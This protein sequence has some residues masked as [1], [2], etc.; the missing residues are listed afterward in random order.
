MSELPVVTY[1]K[2]EYI[3]TA[4][5]NKV[6]RKSVLC[7]AH[8]IILSGKTIIQ[9]GAIVRGDLA[10]VRVG[11]RCVISKHV[12]IRPPYKKISKG[13]TFFP[14]QIGDHVF[15][16]EGSVISA[17]SIGSYV[18]IG[19]NCVIGRKAV[20]RDCCMI[21]DNSVVSPETTVPSYAIY[22]GV[23]ARYAGEL[24]G[25]CQDI[26]ADYTNSYYLNFIPQDPMTVEKK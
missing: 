24:P 19:K 25:P 13:L 3:E 26:M 18:H 23:P 14:Q 12:V 2:Q 16:G 11:R 10:N 4:S 20:L 9:A 1:D 21:A 15:I 22:A 7:G 5:G 8:N 17:Q 6:S